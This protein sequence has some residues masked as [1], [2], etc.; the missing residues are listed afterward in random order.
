MLAMA[1]EEMSGGD[2]DTKLHCR[3]RVKAACL[4]VLGETS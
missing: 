3:D 1:L 2:H 4:A